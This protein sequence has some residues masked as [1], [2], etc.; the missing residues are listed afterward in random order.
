MPGPGTG[1]AFRAERG[2]VA[3]A[4]SACPHRK[5]LASVLALAIAV[6]TGLVYVQIARAATVST[7]GSAT[8]DPGPADAT[9]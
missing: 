3:R 9:Q 5:A 7:V 4:R 6:A 1:S 8:V 2:V